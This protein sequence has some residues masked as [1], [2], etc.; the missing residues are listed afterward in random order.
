MSRRVG[1]TSWN[2]T[3]V[4]KSQGP[5]PSVP[6]R[7]RFSQIFVPQITFHLSRP[8]AI[9]FS[10]RLRSARDSL[11]EGFMSKLKPRAEISCPVPAGMDQRQR[12][13]TQVNAS[14]RMQYFHPHPA[15]APRRSAKSATKK[16][17]T[18]L[19]PCQHRVFSATTAGDNRKCPSRTRPGLE[20]IYVCLAR[21]MAY[22]VVCLVRYV[23]PGAVMKKQSEV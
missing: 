20:E 7:Y 14:C 19:S 22:V 8:L 17:A 4:L 18:P 3:K 16:R 6:R 21:C 9:S 15:P 13:Q 1:W 12:G 10:W 23:W 2:K 5:I 11:D